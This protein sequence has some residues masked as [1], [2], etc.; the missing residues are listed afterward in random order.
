MESNYK[1]YNFEKSLERIDKILNFTSAFEDKKDIP[2]R[3]DLTFTNGYYV[4]C[5][6]LFIDIRDSSKMPEK[7]QKRVLAK[8]Y[9]AYISEIVAVINGSIICKE[10]NIIGDC[11]SAIFKGQIKKDV[12]EV[13]NIAAQVNSL[14][15]VLNYKF[16]KKGYPTIK[17][18]IGLAWGRVL[19]IKSGYSESGISNVVWMGDAVNQGSK[20]CSKA[21]KEVSSPIVVTDDFYHNL[22][23]EDKKLFTQGS[24]YSTTNYYYSSIV[25]PFMDNWIQIQKD[26]ATKN[27][28]SKLW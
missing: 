17:A 2:K 6:S 12:E 4:N 26:K 24:S 20:M 11:V 19:M 1:F 14:I 23:E 16:M 22:S 10:I 21:S 15:D 13:L 18:G 9:R 3:D 5:C 7:H 25:N 28:S 27:K 8:I